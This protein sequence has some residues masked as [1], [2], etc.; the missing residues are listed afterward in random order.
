MFTTD[1]ELKYAKEFIDFI[2]KLKTIAKIKGDQVDQCVG[3]LTNAL[4]TILNEIEKMENSWPS[5]SW[6]TKP[7]HDGLHVV[8]TYKAICDHAL[9]GVDGT[10]KLMVKRKIE[11][12]TMLTH[13]V[14]H[15][16][17]KLH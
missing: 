13:D 15:R 9:E 10:I 16:V 17:K 1:A 2:P 4:N 5:V 11:D 3:G 8:L 7:L 12:V 6:G 14:I